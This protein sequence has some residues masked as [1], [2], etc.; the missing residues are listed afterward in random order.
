MVRRV[1]G[2]SLGAFFRDEVAVPLGL[3]FWIGLP[4]SEERRAVPL[5]PYREAVETDAPDK[6]LAG[7]VVS[8]GV[9]EER[10]WWNTRAAHAAELPASGGLTNARSAARMYAALAMGGSLDGVR[11]VNSDTVT[12][13]ARTQSRLV[14]DALGAIEAP[15]SLGFMKAPESTGLPESGFGH[16][17]AGG[18][19]GTADPS[20]RMS[21]AY[22]MNQM[23]ETERWLPL[24]EAIYRALG[25]CQGRYG[26]W[27][28]Q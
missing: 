28:K 20:A 22:V 27:M 26:I 15:F 6:V 18:S 8:S 5:I 13:M 14:N 16:S 7:E 25:Y 11:L 2:K 4:E 19:V 24:A 21:Y 3:D 23:S 9:N 17:G 10:G 12:R 1:S